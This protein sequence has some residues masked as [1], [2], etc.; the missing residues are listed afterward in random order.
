MEREANGRG[1][2]IGEEGKWER[3]ANGRGRQLG[4]GGK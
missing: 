4:E 2:Q 3:E 1:R